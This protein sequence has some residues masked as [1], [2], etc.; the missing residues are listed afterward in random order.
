MNPIDEFLEL[1]QSV[2]N[3]ARSLRTLAKDSSTLESIDY[4][5]EAANKMKKRLIDGSK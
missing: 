4:I 5:I 1:H 2:I 3:L